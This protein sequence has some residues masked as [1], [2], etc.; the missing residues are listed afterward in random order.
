MPKKGSTIVKRT[1]DL[2]K[3]PRPSAKQQARL[4][5]VAAMPDSKIDYSDAP[6]QPDS[7][8]MKSVDM[9]HRKQQVTLRLDAD[10]LEFFR[11]SGKR[12]QTR[13]NA[14]LRSY[15]EAHKSHRS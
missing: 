2:K 1:I 11:N 14:V 13:I 10:V 8:W 9:P 3:P 6:S 15:V 5:A 7:A 12:Y 4:D